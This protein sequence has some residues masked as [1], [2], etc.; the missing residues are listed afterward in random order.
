MDEELFNKFAKSFRWIMNYDD[1]I[2][3]LMP[4]LDKL[5]KEKLT[6]REQF[7]IE[8]AKESWAAHL[9]VF[10][11]ANVTMSVEQVGTFSVSICTS[12]YAMADMM[13]KMGEKM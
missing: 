1:V 12:A 4:V 5:S 13:T 3:S 6:K 7:A 2:A 10:T 9:R 8:F 11:D